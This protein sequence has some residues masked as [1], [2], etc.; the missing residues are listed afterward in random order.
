MRCIIIMTAASI[1]RWLDSN[2][3]ENK[4]LVVSA[5]FR[6]A[7]RDVRASHEQPRFH[8]DPVH[9]HHVTDTYSGSGTISYRT[10]CMISR[11]GAQHNG[12]WTATRLARRHGAGVMPASH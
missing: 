8:V 6:K 12:S 3:C 11:A 5:T 10:V 4:Q 2:Q 9:S 1:R 7:A